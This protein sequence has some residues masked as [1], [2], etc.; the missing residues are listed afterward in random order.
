MYKD[1]TLR[2][3]FYLNYYFKCPVSKCSHIL[4]VFD[5][6]T[7]TYEFRGRHN[8]AYGRWLSQHIFHKN[9]EI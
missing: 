8:F 3:S 1:T 4:K 9:L 2:T 7:L 6:K 5:F